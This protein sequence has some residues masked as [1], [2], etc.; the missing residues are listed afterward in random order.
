V[1]SI[2]T[3]RRLAKQA[4]AASAA[5]LERCE[6]CS[7]RIPTQHRHVLEVAAHDVHCV[8]SSCSVLFDRNGASQGRYRLIPERRLALPDF[9]LSDAHWQRLRV[10][11]KMA[12]LVRD[13]AEGQPVVFYPS[14][15]GAARAVLEPAVWE[16]LV[17]RN[18]I[19]R[20][21]Q[22][23]VEAL[24]VNRLRGAHEH[25]LTPIDDCYRLVGIIRTTW[26][27]L[28]G[29][30]AVWAHVDDFFDTIRARSRPPR[31]RY[32]MRSNFWKV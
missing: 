24:L 10:P 16:D 1:T 25:Y 14:P 17:E 32:V 26:R 13:S 19:L 30:S 8:C 15:A 9:D 23:D 3:F 21:L 6:L 20:T 31:G 12:Y 22:P 7:A 11:V 29:G 18:L 4:G 2:G 28:S 5:A 27:G